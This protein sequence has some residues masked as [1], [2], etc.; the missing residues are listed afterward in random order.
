MGQNLSQIPG[1][2]DFSGRELPNILI[3]GLM[4]SRDFSGRDQPKIVIPGFLDKQ[5][6]LAPTHVRCKSVGPFVGDTFEFPFYQRLW[7]PYVKS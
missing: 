6:S 3:L 2:R 4:G 7:T 5:M 1:S